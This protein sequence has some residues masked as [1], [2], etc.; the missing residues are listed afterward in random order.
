MSMAL[1]EKV[2]VACMRGWVGP[3]WNFLS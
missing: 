1:G 3:G 2:R